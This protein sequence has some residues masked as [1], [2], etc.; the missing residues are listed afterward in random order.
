S[1]RDRW[2]ARLRL[3]WAEKKNKLF[4]P[5]PFQM[6]R[7]IFLGPISSLPQAEVM[8]D[9]VARC[10]DCAGVV[11][12]DIVFFGEPLPP[13]FLLH[14]ADFPMADL[15]L[16]LGTSL[17]VCRRACVGEELHGWWWGRET[18]GDWGL[19]RAGAR[20]PV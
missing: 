8:A 16:I 13:R 5:F 10:P 12:P 6:C 11:K 9:R 19:E 7:S 18:F 3:L 14:V 15:L 20:R 1:H 17:E 2:R 4:L